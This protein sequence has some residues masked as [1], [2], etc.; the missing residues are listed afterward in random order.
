MCDFT[1]KMAVTFLIPFVIKC[2]KTLIVGATS[3]CDKTRSACQREGM[4]MTMKPLRP[5]TLDDLRGQPGLSRA[6]SEAL[7][8]LQPPTVLKAL[9]MHGVGLKTT[10]RLL[11]LGILTD[12]EGVQTRRLT[13]EE[14]RA[15]R[16]WAETSAAKPSGGCNRGGPPAG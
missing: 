14:F 10:Q 1:H 7:V 4:L 11:A 3:K 16:H 9:M 12:P 5:I 8:A 6:A 2:S 13:S 15:N